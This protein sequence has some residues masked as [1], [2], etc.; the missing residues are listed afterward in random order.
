MYPD[1]SLDDQSDS[2]LEVSDQ[3]AEAPLSMVDNAANTARRRRIATR[4]ELNYESYKVYNNE[5]K[6]WAKY[7]VCK[8]DQCNVILNKKSNF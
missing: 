5:T 8:Y 3:H 1:Q 7:Y 2:S 4:G 6:R